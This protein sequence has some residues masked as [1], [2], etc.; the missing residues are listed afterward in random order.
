LHTAVKGLT[1]KLRALLD[2]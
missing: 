2:S 1:K